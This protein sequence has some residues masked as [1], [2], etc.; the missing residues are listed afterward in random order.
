MFMEQQEWEHRADAKQLVTKFGRWLALALVAGLYK[1]VGAALGIYDWRIGLVALLILVTA[2]INLILIATSWYRLRLAPACPVCGGLFSIKE[3]SLRGSTVDGV[4]N[5]PSII[6]RVSTCSA[7]GREHHQV[8]AATGEVGAVL[9][10]TLQDSFSN[11]MFTQK[12]MLRQRYPGKSEAEIDQLIAQMESHEQ[13]KPPA[14]TREEWERLLAKLQQE[15]T[16]KNR[17]QGME[18]PDKRN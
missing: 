17:E 1:T 12:S 8:Y 18:F 13:S 2:I 16:M 7:C 15:A 5:L 3:N 9:P 14:M 6:D 4:D 11:V 10:I